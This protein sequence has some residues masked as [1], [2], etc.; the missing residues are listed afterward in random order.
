MQV[1]IFCILMELSSALFVAMLCLHGVGRRSVYKLLNL[2]IHYHIVCR[3]CMQCLALP[4][5]DL[6]WL[7]TLQ[8]RQ[9]FAIVGIVFFAL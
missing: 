1:S 9:V 3:G 6:V 8:I 7:S 5:W 2:H 4:T